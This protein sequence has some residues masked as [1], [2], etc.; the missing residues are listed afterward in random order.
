[1]APNTEATEAMRARVGQVAGAA[2]DASVD[3]VVA[4]VYGAL[5]RAPSLLVTAA[6]D[7][8]LGIEER[9]NMPGTVDEWPNWSIALPVSIEEIESDPRPRAIADLLNRRHASEG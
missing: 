6:I 9:P 4:G 1:M 7:D 3:E 2:D 8:A 5:A